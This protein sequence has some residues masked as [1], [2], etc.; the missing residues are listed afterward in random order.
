MYSRRFFIGLFARIFLI[1]MICISIAVI[2]SMQEKWFTILGFAILL[3]LLIFD[4]VRYIV[5]VGNNISNLIVS[6]NNN[7]G[8]S[9]LSKSSAKLIDSKFIENVRELQKSVAFI[10]SE[11]VIQALFIENLLDHIEVGIIALMP[12]GNI[13]FK[14]SAAL[15]LMNLKTLKSLSV[16]EGSNPEFYRYLVGCKPGDERLITLYSENETKKISLKSTRF[17]SKGE[18]IKLV[19]FQNIKNEIDESLLQSWQ[20]LIR[21]LTHEINNTVSPIASLAD[22]LSVYLS[23]EGKRD[24]PASRAEID[25]KA[26]DVSL[27]G[28]NIIK[29]RSNGLIDFVSR[30]RSL[31]PKKSLSIDDIQVAQLFYRL[32][33]LFSEKLQNSKIS[34]VSHVEPED[35]T[36]KADQYYLEQVLIN[37]IANSIDAFVD[38]SPVSSPTILLKSFT[39]SKGETVIQVIDNGSGISPE[40]LDK[41]FLP[42]YS[43]KAKGSGVGLSLSM[44][45]IR[46]HGGTLDVSSKVGEKTIFTIKI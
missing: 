2:I 21:I 38:F 28:A 24:I 26:I 37:L 39:S 18:D 46:L 33:I 4:I 6:L 3:L 44:Q 15:R 16:I 27:E 20:N 45:I 7:E 25:Q 9:L 36:I 40:N 5:Q 19:F 42:F 32:K 14:N 12:N 34:I 35:L 17:I 31:L 43:T 11:Q 13:K 8:S 1:L 10:K 41:V 29:E 30:Y 22:S 23:T